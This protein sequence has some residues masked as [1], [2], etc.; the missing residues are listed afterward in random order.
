MET[1]EHQVMA[2]LKEAMRSKDQAQL[3]TLRAI[4]SAILLEKT[5]GK[6]GELSPEDELK[7]LN[8]LAKQR[9]DALL[10]YEKEGRD[11]LANNER[12]ELII[13]QSY[14]PEQLSP[15]ALQSKIQKIIAD[16]GASNMAD[17]GR[18]MGIASQELLGQA[19]GK[20]ISEE[21]RKQLSQS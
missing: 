2:D 13:I 4:K 5:S 3:R 7:M 21:V 19:D 6:G 9:Q 18:V 20:A 11:E 17:M 14:M 15:E 12:E 16:A 8:K 1:L 10:I